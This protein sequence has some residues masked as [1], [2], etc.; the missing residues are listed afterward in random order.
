[1]RGKPQGGSGRGSLGIRLDALRYDPQSLTTTSAGRGRDRANGHRRTRHI[2]HSHR[3]DDAEGS[4][5]GLRRPRSRVSGAGA[6]RA[7]GEG[8]ADGP[9]CSVVSG[10]PPACARE[11]ACGGT[12][13]AGWWRQGRVHRL[14]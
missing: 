5:P 12:R 8:S 6:G 10:V 9:E 11:T 4:A 1:M 14:L 2:P 3:Q 7:A 13:L